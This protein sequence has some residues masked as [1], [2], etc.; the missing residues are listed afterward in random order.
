MERDLYFSTVT[1]PFE[2]LPQPHPQHASQTDCGRTSMV[3]RIPAIV[4]GCRGQ[5]ERSDA[6]VA[7][8]VYVSDHCC[9]WVAFDWQ[10]CGVDEAL[11]TT[12]DISGTRGASLTAGSQTIRSIACACISG[13]S[14]SVV[15]STCLT[16]MES[17]FAVMPQLVS[18]RDLSNST[19]WCPLGHLYQRGLRGVVRRIWPAARATP[20][21]HTH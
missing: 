21:Y 8:A 6:Y 3:H 19:D 4:G 15:H 13:Y 14:N 20:K 16:L 18:F 17:Y 7:E 12:V 9:W 11:K 10:N 1:D 2:P 5:L